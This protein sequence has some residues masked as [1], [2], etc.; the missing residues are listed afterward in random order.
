MKQGYRIIDTDT[1]VGPSIETLEQFAGPAL[2]A[3]WDE[4]RPYYQPSSEGGHFLSIEPMAYKRQMGAPSADVEAIRGG[5]S[6][7]KGSVSKPRPPY[8]QGVND[9]NSAGR[10]RDM[11]KEGV[12][13]HLIIP[14][15][16]A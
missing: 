12:D 2:A 9:L 1:H 16:F 5:K 7:L 8:E 10:L 11:D 3:R 14:G 6:P 15:T 4:L 13:V